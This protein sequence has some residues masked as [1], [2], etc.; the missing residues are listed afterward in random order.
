M[1]RQQTTLVCIFLTLTVFVYFT[2]C[3]FLF[4][5]L[6]VC[7]TPAQFLHALNTGL[8]W[9]DAI[10]ML[11]ILQIL[12]AHEA[13]HK[14]PRFKRLSFQFLFICPQTVTLFFLTYSIVLYLFHAHCLSFVTDVD[15]F[16]SSVFNVQC[17]ILKCSFVF[18]TCSHFFNSILRFVVFICQKQK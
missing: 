4:L 15:M 2:S 8:Q 7:N 11:C 16:Y 10:A 1:R 14:N 12:D 3:A 13:K 5:S 9:S 6:F 18:M 17:F